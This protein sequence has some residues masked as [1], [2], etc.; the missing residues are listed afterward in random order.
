[1][2]EYDRKDFTVTIPFMRAVTGVFPLLIWVLMLMIGPTRPVLGQVEDVGLSFEPGD[3]GWQSQTRRGSWSPLRL[4][5]DNRSAQ[6]RRVRC[7]WVVPDYGGDRAYLERTVTLSPHR[8]QAVW[9]YAP[10]TYPTN[11]NTDWQVRVIDDATDR[12]LAFRAFHPPSLIDAETAVIATT[13]ATTLGLAPYIRAT[14]KDQGGYRKTN[15]TQHEEIEL[16]R[17]VAPERLPD[18][19]QGYEMLEAFIWTPDAIQPD[20]G[21][22]LPQTLRAMREWVQRGGHLIVVPPT[23]GD[24]WRDSVLGSILPAGRMTTL[25]EASA[26]HWLTG[27]VFF[28]DIKVGMKVFEQDGDNRDTSV[29][30]RDREGRAVVVARQV[31]LGRV[32][33]IGV[34]LT[35]PRLIR[36]GHPSG[37]M[38]WNTI[39]N[40]QGEA[41]MP[42]VI[43]G[44]LQRDEIVRPE[45]RND[46]ELGVFAR[47][48]INMKESASTAVLLSIVLFILY[49]L[50][51]GPISFAWLKSRQ[52][53]HHSWLVFTGVV[54]VFS[55]VS[56][57]AA[58]FLR[59][60][61]ARIKH[62]SVV[63]FDAGGHRA[64]VHSWLSVF[65]PR[66]GRAEVVIDPAAP[67][68]PHDTLANVGMV[69][70]ALGADE[71][72]Y[73][74]SQR[75]ILPAAAPSRAAFPVRATPRQLEVDYVGD[76]DSHPQ[77]L[78]VDWLAPR[79]DV[80]AEGETLHGRLTHQLP[81]ELRDV[82][83]V[84]CPGDGNMPLVWPLGATV[85]WEPG[86]VLNLDKITRQPAMPLI[87][88]PRFRVD[89]QG[90]RVKWGGFLGYL[91]DRGA[92]FG[93][94][95]RPR[96][97]PATAYRPDQVT[98]VAEILTFYST[99]PPP[100]YQTSGMLGGGR[101]YT[102]ALGR[103]FDIT[104]LL[105]LRRVIIMGHLQR[106]PLPLPLT[107]DGEI[108]PSEGWTVVRWISQVEGR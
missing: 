81:G 48:E 22:I 54:A 106:S 35:D 57:G 70:Q 30:L 39:F 55:V 3:V 101:N 105:P 69:S 33:V 45:F 75:Y 83:V 7:A 107:V 94:R 15:W 87:N 63:D 16:I 28:R 74:D 88:E 21:S 5:L 82:L 52:M 1:M 103:P 50:A 42:K 14:F 95:N 11:S 92:A 18:R 98:R 25:P 71:S 108:L 80:R 90:K 20:S 23:E 43:E 12:S 44:K 9:L 65:V 67:D 38:L 47:D 37:K 51:A 19:W 6:P 62:V 26:P 68:H 89:D 78:S 102:R 91:V 86:Q 36:R 27:G 93:G 8:E 104:A 96:F 61:Q 17:G 77:G 2:I 66:H 99:L 13:S 29:L 56:W 24:P 58:Y 85:R 76:L 59:P 60:T 100:D 64:R 73:T 53:A 41:W 84:F 97:N 34:N 32:T 46:V 10:L 49:W 4:R 31:G 72:G 40:W 79:G